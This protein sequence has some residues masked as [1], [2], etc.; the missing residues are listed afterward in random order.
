MAVISLNLNHEEEE[1]FNNYSE[2]TG[3]ELSV[4]L[5][6]ALID[7]IEDRFDYQAGVKGYEE[8]KKDP[9]T[10]SIDEVIGELF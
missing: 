8:Y 4:L 10:Y 7:E 9:K 2:Y 3:E 1:L 6:N 5:K